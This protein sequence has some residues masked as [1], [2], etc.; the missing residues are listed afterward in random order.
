M[1]ELLIIFFFF[2]NSFNYFEIEI[3]NNDGINKDL[4]L[5]DFDNFVDK[6]NKCDC[7]IYIAN[8]EFDVL[9]SIHSKN[10]GP[11]IGMTQHDDYYNTI[12]LFNEHKTSIVLFDM[13]N[14]NNETFNS[15]ETN[16]NY[17]E[18]DTLRNVYYLP[19][20]YFEF[21]KYLF[22]IKK[23]STCSFVN[24]ISNSFIDKHAFKFYIFF[25]LYFKI[26]EFNTYTNETK[27]KENCKNYSKNHVV[28]NTDVGEI[29]DLSQA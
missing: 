5:D 24:S 14:S 20:N 8:S 9:K 27:L 28:K 6:L 16:F 7:I 4:N 12:F 13:N 23:T 29:C 15:N 17:D 25:K 21:I 22:D 19:K 26:K 10:N 11:C 3:I 1:N 2:Q 18:K